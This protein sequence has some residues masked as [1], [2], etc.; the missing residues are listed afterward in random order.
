MKS[1]FKISFFT[2]SIL[3]GLYLVMDKN[4]DLEKEN[5]EI[6]EIK[7]VLKKQQEC[8]NNGDIDGFMLGYWNSEELIFTST[9]HIPAYGWQNTL[10][11]YKNSYTTKESMGQLKFDFL[12][13]KINSDSIS[14]NL[15][16]SWELIRK[17]NNPGGE[18]YLELRKFEDK[19]KIIKDST[20]SY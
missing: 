8:W 17:D 2:I 5:P 10:E 14:A 4:K 19:W 15:T 3:L 20:T 11:R 6:S 9:K 13:V 7:S 1:L 16:G 18:F 12:N